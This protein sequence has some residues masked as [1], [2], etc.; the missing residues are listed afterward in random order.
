MKGQIFKFS[1]YD[2]VMILYF[3]VGLYTNLPILLTRFSFIQ[4]NYVGIK[5]LQIIF[6]QFLG[7]QTLYSLNFIVLYNIILT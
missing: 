3:K 1:L 2:I 6:Y 4:S 7:E 5:L